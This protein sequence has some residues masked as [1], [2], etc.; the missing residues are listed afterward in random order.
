L[1]E[2]NKEIKKD[3][4]GGRRY[5]DRRVKKK[6]ERLKS[7][8]KPI[9]SVGVSTRYLFKDNKTIKPTLNV[10]TVPPKTG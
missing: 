7:H 2:R 9:N 5:K 4:K 6:K 8:F 1:K 10:K 3:R